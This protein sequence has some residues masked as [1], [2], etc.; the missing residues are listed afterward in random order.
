MIESDAAL[1]RA[2][3]ARAVAT[4]FLPFVAGYL[5]SN[6]FR[7]VNAVVGPRIGAELGL[8]L[9]ALG[10]LTSAY[11]AGFSLMQIPAGIGQHHGIRRR[12]PGCRA[13]LDGF[14]DPSRRW[15]GIPAFVTVDL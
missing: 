11:F 9:A 12:I 8:D 2:D 7:V 13:S 10:V 3:F 6:V 5:L 15:R 4:G 1:P 14:E